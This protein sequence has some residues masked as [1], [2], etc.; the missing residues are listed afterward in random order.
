M[1]RACLRRPPA[2]WSGLRAPR[3]C[4]AFGFRLRAFEIMRVCCPMWSVPAGWSML[5]GL[6]GLHYSSRCWR[7][8]PT[9]AAL[10][11]SESFARGTVPRLRLTS[12]AEAS[13]DV[14]ALMP[15]TR[16]RTH[17]DLRRESVEYE[18]RQALAVLAALRSLLAHHT[19]GRACVTPPELVLAVVGA[20]RG[21]PGSFGLHADILRR[22]D[23]VAFFAALLT[24]IPAQRL[25]L[26]DKSPGGGWRVARD[27][28]TLTVPAGGV[29]EWPRSLHCLAA[30]ELSRM[31]CGE[32]AVLLPGT[33]L[34][35]IARRA[36]GG[37]ALTGEVVIQPS[38]TSH[39]L[40]G[41]RVMVFPDLSESPRCERFKY[42]LCAVFGS[43]P[44][45]DS[46]ADAAP[47]PFVLLRA[48]ECSLWWQREKAGAYVLV[49]PAGL[50]CPE[51]VEGLD[52]PALAELGIQQRQFR[53]AWYERRTLG[54][55][56]CRVDS[57]ALCLSRPAGPRSLRRSP[58]L[59]SEVDLEA[60][61]RPDR[62]D[63]AGAGVV[64]GLPRCFER[65]LRLR[66][67]CFRWLWGADR[68]DSSSNASSASWYSA[69]VAAP[70]GAGGPVA[71]PPGRG[72]GLS[73]R[74]V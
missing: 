28:P 10:I 71:G 18:H 16:R 69:L 50:R 66:E 60:C 9:W 72:H 42:H 37:A 68:G 48:S 2:I 63:A 33:L 36:E 64:R 3:C 65:S 44:S 14:P 46:E 23:P 58:T 21:C 70:A 1:R 11:T 31:A 29:A 19:C 57:S 25:A 8:H 30:E 6:W 7:A 34:I 27:F 55:C 51:V 22:D 45:P 47:A 52:D 4:L 24:A 54:S 5:R 59:A 38:F 62:T 73:P 26:C 17:G 15:T 56:D 39:D 20:L 43:V 53:A 40:L 49:F 74:S 32:Q 67:G 61:S 35:A 12:G 41:Q 13:P